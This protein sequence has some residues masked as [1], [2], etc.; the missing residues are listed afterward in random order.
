M[1]LPKALEQQLWQDIENIEGTRKVRYVTS[2]ERIAIEQGLEKGLEQGIERGRREGQQE[3]LSGVLHRQ[4]TRR[5]GT[6]PAELAQRLSQATPEQLEIWADRV[7]DATVLDE[8][9]VEN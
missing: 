5:F 9:F 4:L 2:I 8:V 3:A 1:K 7:L 6:L